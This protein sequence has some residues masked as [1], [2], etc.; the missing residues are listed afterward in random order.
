MV[1]S[2]TEVTVRKANGRGKLPGL[3]DREDANSG[4]GQLPD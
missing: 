4:L 2:L 3:I 1:E